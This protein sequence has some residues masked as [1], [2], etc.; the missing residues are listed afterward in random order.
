MP[1]LLPKFVALLNDAERT[2]DF[3]LVRW[4]GVVW[5]GVGQQRRGG[6]GDA[7]VAAGACR[8]LRP[9]LCPPAPPPPVQV[10]PALDAIRALG[11]VLE[12]HLQL[13]LPALNRLIVPGAPGL[14]LAVQE[15]TLASMQDLLP[16]MQLAGFS[17][18][19]MHPLIRLLDGP[20][21][22]LQERAL[23]T[24]CSV[25]LAIGPDFAI[26]VPT[27]KK[28]RGGGAAGLRGEAWRVEM[29]API[30]R[31]RTVGAPSRLTAA[32]PPHPTSLRC[33]SWR[34][35]AWHRTPPSTASP[36]SCSTTSRRACQRRTTGRA[37]PA[38][39]LRS[40][41]PSRASPRLTACTWSAPPP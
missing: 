26:F 5:G 35:T 22:E 30:R 7:A 29:G 15:E 34:G 2:N 38:S 40:T 16:R 3:T 23:D 17:S 25:S 8:H 18:M 6:T 28:A 27:I 13:L 4:C 33:R 11:P 9:D 41:W 37:A 14:P 10:K 20:S 36:P 21:E 31:Q 1:D 39:W 24:L 12:D 19:V 32:H